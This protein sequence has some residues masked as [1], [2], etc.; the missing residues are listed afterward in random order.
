M[1]SFTLMKTKILLLQVLGSF[2]LSLNAQTNLYNDGILKLTAG[3]DILYVTGSFTNTSSASLTNNGNLYIL[4]D[5]DNAQASMSAGTGKLYLSGSA[6]QTV[7]GTQP[8]KTYDLVSNNS[9]GIILN[10]NLSVSGAHTF[11]NGVITTSATP[12]YLIYE[13]GSSYSGSG[14]TKHVNGW[15]KKI[16]N[17]D[18]TF[19]VGNGT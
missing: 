10:N 16:G 13:P 9:S 17:T 8:F 14:D 2:A 5:L 12:N 3:S 18:F 1:Q 19:P 7:S 6:L 11:T 4:R 15:V